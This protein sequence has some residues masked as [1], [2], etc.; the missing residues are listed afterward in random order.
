MRGHGF[1]RTYLKDFKTSMDKA[2]AQVHP[3]SRLGSQYE[4]D[5]MKS[6]RQARTGKYDEHAQK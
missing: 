4:I 3:Y 2:V 6:Y 1:L 5:R